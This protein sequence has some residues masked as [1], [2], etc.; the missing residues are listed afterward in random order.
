MIEDISR[1]VSISD[2][3]IND[4]LEKY[5]LDRVNLSTFSSDIRDIGLPEKVADM[6]QEARQRLVEAYNKYRAAPYDWYYSVE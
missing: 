1:D 5:C 3:R 4:I 6:P 2:G